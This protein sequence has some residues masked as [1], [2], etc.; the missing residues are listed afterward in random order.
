M[1]K[2]PLI[3]AI[4]GLGVLGVGGYFWKQGSFSSASGAASTA[5]A[6]TTNAS[7]PARPSSGAAGPA[8]AGAPGGPATVEV[9]RVQALDLQDDAQAVGNLRSRQGVIVRPEVAGRIAQLG[10]TDGQAVK[11]GQLLVQLDDVLQRAELKQAEAQLSIAQANFNRN[12]D[13]VAQNFVAQRVLDESSANLD[14]ARAQVQLAQAR[15]SRMKIVAPFDGITGIKSVGF[16]DYIKDGADI[17]NLEDISAVFTDFRLPERYLSKLVR[18][19]TVETTLDAVPGKTFTGL[20]E[21]IDPQLD[22]NGRNVLV[23]ARID[24]RAAQLRPGMFARVRVLFGERKGALMVP[25]EALVPQGNKQFVIK[26]VDAEPDAPGKPATVASKPGEPQKP[27]KIARRVEVKTGLRRDGK[28][29]L[30]EGVKPGDVVVTAGQQRLQRDGA[31]VRV[32]DLSKP[33]GADG[34]PGIG[35]AGGKPAGAASGA[36]SGAAPAASA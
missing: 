3:V 15:L 32:L 31:P 20:I 25:E 36:A 17:V 11:K 2:I 24:N 5:G 34:K 33:R 14:V 28:V 35:G 23:R 4:C 21:A 1:K 13:L 29:E 22:A 19:Q 9:A 27:S 18:G 7:N 26:V 16:G 30:T 10:F 12:K 8:R 6:L